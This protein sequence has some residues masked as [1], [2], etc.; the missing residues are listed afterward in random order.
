MSRVRSLHFQG[1]HIYV[2]KVSEPA[3]VLSQPEGGIIFGIGTSAPIN[4]VTCSSSYVGPVQSS[5]Y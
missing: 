3:H 1:R 4:N 5:V 2:G